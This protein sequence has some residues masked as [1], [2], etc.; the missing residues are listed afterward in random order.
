[1]KKYSFKSFSLIEI[2]IATMIFMTVIVLAVSSFGMVKKSNET[3]VDMAKTAE[4]VRQIG[5]ISMSLFKSANYHEP[6]LMRILSTGGT[7]KLIEPDEDSVDADGFA[8]FQPSDEAGKIYLVAVLK[9]TTGDQTGY[10]Y[11]KAEVDEEL[12]VNGGNI[13]SF[14]NSTDLE[15]LHSKDCQALIK[16]GSEIGFEGDYEKPFALTL[17]TPFSGGPSSL[18]GNPIYQIKLND[19]IFSKFS[20]QEENDKTFSRLFLEGIN[21]VKPI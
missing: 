19:I 14:I 2:L 21:N 18:Q 5:N 13:S 7:Y 6:R 1:M 12:A 3:T 9:K 16:N 20:S 17:S 15:P 8:S 4:C 11:R 10:Y